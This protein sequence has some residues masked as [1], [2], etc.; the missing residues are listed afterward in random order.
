[1]SK[2]LEIDY[3]AYVYTDKEATNALFV[4]VSTALILMM[5]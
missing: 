3:N 1:M 2:T 4:F 5:Q